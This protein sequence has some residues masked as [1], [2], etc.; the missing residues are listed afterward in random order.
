MNEFDA[1]TWRFV[2]LLRLYFSQ[3]ANYSLQVLGTFYRPWA[4]FDDEELTADES[5]QL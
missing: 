2:L 4:S 5:C 3:H 1:C